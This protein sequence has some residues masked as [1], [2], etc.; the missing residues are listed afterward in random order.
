MSSEPPKAEE[1]NVPAEEPAVADI[2]SATDIGGA[3][4]AR[5][6]DLEARL[7]AAEAEQ[8]KHKDQALRALA[9]AENTRR[10]IQ[11]EAE[12]R[13][14]YALSGF[15]RELTSVVDNLR[16]AIETVPPETRAGDARLDQ[17]AQGVELTEREFMA[18]LERNG[19]KRV[20][21]TGQAFDHNLHQAIA[22]A[23]SA[24]HAPGTVV[25]VV[26]AGYTLH[27]RILRPAMVVVAKPPAQSTQ[28]GATIDTTA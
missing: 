12:E 1:P 9:E 20:A 8:A 18:I 17:F 15:A 6:A 3:L 10:R 24:E 27:G 25:Q 7:A 4:M 16:R 23:E 11:R 22:Q 5:I 26:Q 13:E 21:P 14:R 28:P 19:I 2:G